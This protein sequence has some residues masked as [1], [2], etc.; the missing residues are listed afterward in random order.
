LAEHYVGVDIGGTFTDVVLYDVDAEA[1]HNAKVL[2]TP[3]NY[4]EGIT[5]GIEEV[6]RNYEAI[7]FLVHGTTA[8]L[9]AILERRGVNTALLTT[10]GFKDVYEI[11]RAN[12]PDMYNLFFQKPTPLVPRASIYE[13]DERI[14]E[15]G[16]VDVPLSKEGMSD[17]IKNLK[18]NGYDSIAVCFLHAYANPEHENKVREILENELPG[19]SISLSSEVAREWREYE[20][21]STVAM[22]AYVAPVV[23][24]YLNTL[25]KTLKE[26]GFKN[27]LHIMQSNGGLM[28]STAAKKQAVHSLMSGPV[29]GT[30]GSRALC[31]QLG[32]NNLILVDMGGTSFDF[33]L[34]IEGGIDLA[35]EATLEG[36]PL[37]STMAN[38][39]S[40]GAGGGSVAWIEAGGLRVGPKSAG[41]DPGPVCYNLGGQELTVTDANLILGRIDQD[42]FLGGKMQLDREK[43]NDISEHVA[44]ELSLD[45]DSL[46]EG[47]I[48]IIDAK[49]ANG[50]RSITVG[51][52]IDPRDFAL[53]AYGGA[54]PM[55]C[56]ALAEELGI[57]KVVIPKSPGTFSAWGM[58]HTDIQH[59][60]VQTLFGKVSKVNPEEV[61]NTFRELEND[62]RKVLE[63]EGIPEE[64]MLFYRTADIRY[65]GQEYFLNIS[66]PEKIDEDAMITIPD[67][68]HGAYKQRYGHSN[69]DEDIE[70]VNLRI[71]AV[72]QMEK[73]M[74]EIVDAKAERIEM[75]IEKHRQV[76]FKGEWYNAA[77]VQRKDLIPGHYLV[78][79]AIIEEQSCTTVIP[80]CYEASVDDYS[81]IIIVPAS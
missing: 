79:P 14:L 51:K 43:T 77:I 47:I 42:N 46:A 7:S 16:T 41:A 45:R 78:G 6:A 26:K 32:E 75:P 31:E 66:V 28:T 74:V 22:N 29:G 69:P 17:V 80:P 48:K 67:M 40:I 21:T 72:G 13:V 49:M 58:L 11:G 4:S 38:I 59:D 30:I 15:D 2:S 34:I 61:E 63:D 1:Y 8:G 56:V 65:V 62:G 18:D 37:L 44:Q 20:R 64:R 54:G 24:K 55:H 19:V 35:T 76:C 53:V 73:E 81:N 3:N 71:Q 68:F 50:I 52:G 10:K 33:S 70:F 9:N 27:T 60:L 36:F 23:E 5:R 12:R 39:Y 57:N 25:E